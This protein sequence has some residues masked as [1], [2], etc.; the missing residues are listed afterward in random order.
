MT[1]ALIKTDFGEIA[2]EL[3]ENDA[4]K[5]CANFIKLA[6]EKFYDNLIFHRVVKDYVIQGGCPKGDGT[7]GPGWTIPL[8]VTQHKHIP[9][10]VGMARMQEPDTAGSQFYICCARLE[11]LDGKYC[12]FGQVIRGMDVV[13]KIEEV[14]VEPFFIGGTALHKPKEP[15]FIRSVQIVKEKK[16]T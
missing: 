3:F 13:R 10:A 5:T 14:E 6:K 2:I 7:G 12:I 11:H 4:P 1:V 9:G 8:E 16:K 15:V